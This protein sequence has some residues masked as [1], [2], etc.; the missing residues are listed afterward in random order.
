[1]AGIIS[2]ANG[3]APGMVMSA[4]G[5]PLADGDHNVALT[6][7][8]WCWVDG[9]DSGVQPGDMLTSSATPGHAK[10]VS[11]RDRAFGS[12]IGKAM[13]PLAQGEK[14]LVLVLVNLQ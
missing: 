12:V 9:T 2:G 7:R 4:E 10:R 3:L 5:N 8:V 14:G 1:V 13:T 11:D 6:G